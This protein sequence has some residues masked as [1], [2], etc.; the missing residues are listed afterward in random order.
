MDITPS[1]LSFSAPQ[2]K[3]LS[4]SASSSVDEEEKIL[5]IF[6]FDHRKMYTV[7]HSLLVVVRKNK[8][9]NATG[10]TSLKS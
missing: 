1:P 9:M 8:D 7:K 4:R 10:V 3:A 2:I 6:E 5:F